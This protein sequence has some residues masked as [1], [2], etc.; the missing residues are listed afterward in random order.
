VDI[1]PLFLKIIPP[2]KGVPLAR[3]NGDQKRMFAM[4]EDLKEKFSALNDKFE[5]L[6]GYL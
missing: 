5:Q 1:S 3:L 2:S 4:H 6:R